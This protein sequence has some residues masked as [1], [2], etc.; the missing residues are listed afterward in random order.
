M[1]RTK[2]YSSKN[3]KV[4]NV[5]Q[6]RKN[7]SR[8]R[9]T[10]KQKVGNII[11]R[12][13]IRKKQKGGTPWLFPKTPIQKKEAKPQKNEITFWELGNKTDLNPKKIHNKPI[14]REKRPIKKET[15][16]NIQ[17]YMPYSIIDEADHEYFETIDTCNS[18]YD[19]IKKIYSDFLKDYFDILYDK[20][21]LNRKKKKSQSKNNNSYIYK[22]RYGTYTNEEELLR[23][24]KKSE[25]DWQEKK[26][27]TLQYKTLQVDNT[28]INI[29]IIY[30]YK[31][32]VEKFQIFNNIYIL[33]FYISQIN[34]PGFGQN[35]YI[36]SFIEMLKEN[37]K[38]LDITITIT[39]IKNYFTKN[40]INIY[41]EHNKLKEYIY[42]INNILD[43][44]INEL[45]LIS[46]INNVSLKYNHSFNITINKLI[47]FLERYYNFYFHKPTPDKNIAYILKI[48]KRFDEETD[49][50][51]E[52]EKEFL[53]YNIINY[54]HLQKE[55]NPFIERMKKYKNSIDSYYRKI[56]E[57]TPELLTKKYEDYRII[58]QSKKKK[59]LE[60]ENPTLFLRDMLVNKTIEEEKAVEN[61]VNEVAKAA[62]AAAVAAG[63][64]GPAQLKAEK[65]RQR[66]ASAEN[67]Y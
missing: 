49:F 17:Q 67:Y 47:I 28:K 61:E 27:E 62:E 25:E 66:A 14:P 2:K 48:Y 37:I 9:K 57:L 55:M 26:D 7:K 12:R 41:N 38:M 3:K 65:A 56:E 22:D 59:Q 31:I 39:I 23:K 35:G 42:Y 52:F 64:E 51:T 19:N 43:Y 29:S 45:K 46:Y 50:I 10:R 30:L 60:L 5:R 4:K 6:L 54:E 36:D 18:N 15:N 13:S 40:P 21:H 53:T 8:S 20:Y 63:A 11:K 44:I 1:A 33:C 58:K 34:S 16:S 24:I 32:I